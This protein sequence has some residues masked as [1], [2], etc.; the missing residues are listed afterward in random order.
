MQDLGGRV[1]AT[2]IYELFC[3]WARAN[4]ETVWAMK[5]FTSGMQERGF[6]TKKSSLSYWLD[7]KLIK[8]LHDFPM[9]SDR[10]ARVGDDDGWKRTDD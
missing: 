10:Q 4:G 5:G 6:A 2:V 8:H 7:L 3:A 1:Q 9:A